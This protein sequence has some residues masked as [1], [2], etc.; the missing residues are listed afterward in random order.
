MHVKKC[1]VCNLKIDENNS[2][3]DRNI[4]KNCYKINRKKIKN[5]EKKSKQKLMTL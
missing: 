3:K 2:K 4:C 5:R 1:T